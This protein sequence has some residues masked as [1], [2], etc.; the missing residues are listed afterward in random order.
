MIF[1]REYKNYQIKSRKR[2]LK[3]PTLNVLSNEQP[4]YNLT[5][6]TLSL[7]LRLHCNIYC[8]GGGSAW[9][10]PCNQLSGNAQYL[11]ILHMNLQAPARA[12]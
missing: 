12:M 3:T 5:M 10:D 2:Y 9:T 7:N 8:R 1:T 6:L 11:L 4:Y